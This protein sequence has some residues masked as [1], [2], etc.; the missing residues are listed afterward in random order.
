MEGRGQGRLRFIDPRG[1]V[2][3]DGSREVLQR[4]RVYGG[5]SQEMLQTGR[6]DGS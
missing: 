5:R 6:G 3:G 2:H 1:R 4:R